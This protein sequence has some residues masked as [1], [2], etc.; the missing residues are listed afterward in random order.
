MRI[1]GIDPGKGG[2]IACIDKGFEVCDM[3]VFEEVVRKKKKK[4]FDK[5]GISETLKR[6]TKDTDEILVYIEQQR[7]WP[8]EGVISSFTAG[9]G[10]GLLEGILTCLNIPYV[11][12]TAQRWQKVFGIVKTR[13]TKNASFAFCSALFPTATLKTERGRILDGRSDALL[14]A[15]Y[16]KR[17]HEG[18][19]EQTKKKKSP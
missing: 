5:R 3:P 16:G 8:G 1:I 4:I 10:C 12:V 11:F 9:R 2:G 14:I 13:N 6:M 17:L 7:P 18:Q 15:E 19:I